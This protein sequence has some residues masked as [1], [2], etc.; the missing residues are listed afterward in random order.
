MASKPNHSPPSEQAAHAAAPLPALFRT[1][2]AEPAPEEAGGA[3]A[4]EPEPIDPH[5]HRPDLKARRS[6]D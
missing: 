2:K 6:Y 3:A 4:A 1:V 5:E